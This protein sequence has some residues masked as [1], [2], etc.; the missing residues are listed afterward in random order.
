MAVT[1]INDDM[2]LVHGYLYS[3][4]EETKSKKSREVYREKLKSIIM[5]GEPDEKGNYNY[6]FP[7]PVN[8]DDVWYTG[9]QMQ[10]RV[11]EYTDEDKVLE[12]ID[13]H[14][15]RDRCVEKIVTYEVDLD[16]LYAANQEGII[17]DDEI[18]SIIEIDETYSLI[19]IK[20]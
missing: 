5:S 3:L 12:I 20:Q 19:R 4:S 15:L 17:S 14:D 6:E 9:L 10:R 16:E 18:D 1:I 2:K 7:Q 13:K 8:I 11:S